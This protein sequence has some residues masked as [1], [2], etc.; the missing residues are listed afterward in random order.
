MHDRAV[1]QLLTA[2]LSPVALSCAIGSHSSRDLWVRL[3]E[4]FSTVSRT[5][6]FQMKSNLQNIRKGSDT[7]GQYLLKIKEARDYLAAAGVYFA[8]EDIVILALNG[9][10]PEYNTF[11]CVVRGRESVITLKE[12]RSQ[13]LAEEH[14]VENLSVAPSYLTAMAATSR[15]TVSSAPPFQQSNGTHGQPSYVH[16]GHKNFH[17]NRGKGR[18]N[19]GQRPFNPR[20]Q[21]YTQ[22]HVLPTPTPG[23]LG[24]FPTSQYTSPSAP[25]V[26]TCQLCNSEGHTAPFCG[27]NPPE[28]SKC[29]IC[30]KTN[31]TTWYCFYNDHGP[32]FIGAGGYS[33]APQM[34]SSSLGY[35]SAQSQHPQQSPMQAMHT[36]MQPSQQP[37]SQSLPQVWLTDSGATNHMTADLSTLSL[38]TPY[39]TNETVQTANG[40]GLS[41]KAT[42]RILYKGLC[43]NG[44]YPI[45]LA[46]SH[47]ALTTTKLQPQA[48]L[49]QLVIFPSFPLPRTSPPLP[50]VTNTNIVA[51]PASHDTTASDAF[52]SPSIT[53]ASSSSP[54]PLSITDASPSLSSIPVVPE[55]NAGALSTDTLPLADSFQP[56]SMPVVLAVPPMNL[57]PMQT[58]SKS[59]IVKKKVFLTTLQESGGVDLALVEPATYR[60]AL[61]VP[62]W[63]T[64]MKEEVDALH[65]QGT[66]SLVPLPPNKNLVGCK[67]IFKIKK[68]ADGSIARHKARLVAKGFSQEPGQDYGET[69]SPVV[70]PTTVRIVLALAAHFGWPL[71]QLDVKNAFLHGI[72]QE[73]VY[74]AQP[75]GFEDS[76]HPTLVCKLHK[77]LYGLKQAPRAW[78]DRFTSFLPT[79]GFQHTY[80]D[81]SLFV[82]QVDSGIVILLVYVD[83]IIITGSAISEI[84][85]VIHSLTVEFELKD[86]GDLHYFLGIQI[87]RTNSG[88]FLS[89]SKYVQDLLVKTEMTEA[90]ACD[91]PCLPY[92][93]LLKDDG[94]PYGNPTLY[95]SI[96]GAL[97]YLTFTRPDIAFSV[98]Q[99]C[100]FMQTPMVSHFT[101]VKRI[102]RYLK[103]TMSFGL[104]YTRG[105]LNLTAFSD[106]DWAGD[107]NDRRST[108][109]LVVFLGSNPVS[110]S[111]KKQ[112]T[113][114][115]SSTEA[116][117]RALST[118][119]AELDWIK[120]LLVFLQV[121]IAQQPVLFCD[122]LSAIALSFNLVQSIERTKHIEIDV[123][124]VRERVAKQQLFVR[125][126]SSGETVL[127]I[128]SPKD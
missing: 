75:P 31:H 10:P 95:R 102:L 110:W 21:F 64:A 48:Y 72:L 55:S 60:S 118:T 29:H 20:P 125:F 101:A 83:D 82:K 126:V 88:L 123:H 109:G 13:L 84:H 28:R 47:S 117:Y 128:Y 116:E 68:H 65:S 70:Q 52:I 41:D 24:Q 33:Q 35:S 5:S 121:P 120:Q 73:E 18:F 54:S 19:Q 91:T 76:H 97:Q 112:Q 46:S 40:E 79:L 9:L 34:P 99:V 61:K 15:P 59:G 78:N 16:G 122:N 45:P 62:V 105:N 57:H 12:F 80:S 85:K 44:L 22:T 49:G 25:L 11:R 119:S 113:V 42:G 96:V 104:R 8:D 87:S 27:S 106:A 26:P 56:E 108:T 38:A 43:S 23:V 103:G 81:S 90:K 50:V 53:P 32:N 7:I 92:H 37:S 89:Q 98:H 14:I 58:R 71:R 115:R 51:L 66:W 74:M 39:P 86:L 17:R 107:P 2:T 36:V 3:K 77:S 111:S 63:L 30:G 100:Q 94:Q 127:A 6:I 4:Q 67:W 114:S 124:F 93:R 69:F 1:M